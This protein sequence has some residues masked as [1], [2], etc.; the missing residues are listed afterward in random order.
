MTTLTEADVETAALDWLSAL[1]W[2]V[3]HGADIA[4]GTSDAE[5]D[6]YDQV[7][8][9]RRLTGGIFIRTVCGSVT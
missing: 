8:L 4:P 2:T 3:A 1:G 7:I 5:R 9:E 6:S